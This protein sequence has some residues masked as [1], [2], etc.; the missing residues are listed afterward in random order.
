MFFLVVDV[1]YPM[2]ASRFESL[3]RKIDAPVCDTLMGKGTFPGEDPA[4]TGML[5]YAWNKDIKYWSIKS[6]RIDC[7]WYTFQ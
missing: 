2:P 1:F 5:G 4:Y 3:L 7:D 6:R